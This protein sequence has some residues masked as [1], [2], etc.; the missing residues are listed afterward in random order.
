MNNEFV[1]KFKFKKS[2]WFSC[3]FYSDFV[4]TGRLLRYLIPVL[5][6]IFVAGFQYFRYGNVGNVIMLFGV[7]L[8]YIGSIIVSFLLTANKQFKEY[9]ANEEVWLLNDTG[10]SGKMFGEDLNSV[11][12]DVFK[13]EITKKFIY[14]YMNALLPIYLPRN[15]FS[16]EAF[17]FMVKKI[18]GE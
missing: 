12:E 3:V 10:V 9:H 14:L 7:L 2:E 11:W 17:D 6:L 13:C 5:L 15:A 18:N 16:K 8:V 1:L 4:F